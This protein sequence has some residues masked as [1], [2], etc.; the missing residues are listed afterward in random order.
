MSKIKKF[1]KKE[2][3][4]FAMGYPLY[5]NKAKKNKV[6]KEKEKYLRSLGATNEDIE[7]GDDLCPEEFWFHA[8]DIVAR[9][10]QELLDLKEQ[11][12]DCWSEFIEDI[13]RS[14]D[15]LAKEVN[16]INK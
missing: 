9:L 1:T 11:K 3:E 13:E 7:D 12:F 8:C 15:Q 5:P 2:L 4:Y 10:A 16:K 14:L 6:E